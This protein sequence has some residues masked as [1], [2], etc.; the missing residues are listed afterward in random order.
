MGNL[1]P[2]GKEMELRGYD[3]TEGDATWI[4]KTPTFSTVGETSPV[5]LKC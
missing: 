5:D 3:H 1:A 2:V 4:R